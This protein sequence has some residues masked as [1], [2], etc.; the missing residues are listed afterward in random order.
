MSDKSYYLRYRGRV[1]GPYTLAQVKTVQQWGKL[2]PVHEIS[3]DKSTWKPA[4][5][6]AELFGPAP[7]AKPAEDKA[8]SPVIPRETP[9][10]AVADQASQQATHLIEFDCPN[11]S[12]VIKVPAQYGGRLGKCKACGAKVRI[13]EREKE[14]ATKKCPACGETIKAEAQKCRFCG[15]YLE[16]EAVK[17]G[18]FAELGVDELALATAAPTPPTVGQIKPK[19]ESRFDQSLLERIFAG[20]IPGLERIAS[21]LDMPVAVLASTL[22]TLT[23]VVIGAAYTFASGIP[24]ATPT[25][26][27]EADTMRLAGVIFYAI[28]VLSAIGVLRRS[29]FARVFLIILAV[30]AILGGVF[31]ILLPLSGASSLKDMGFDKVGAPYYLAQAAGLLWG[32][33]VFQ[34]LNTRHIKEWF[35]QGSASPHSGMRVCQGCGTVTPPGVVICTKC[36]LDLRTGRHVSATGSLGGAGSSDETLG[37]L[38]AALPALSTVLMWL[39]IPELSLLE[40][41][42]NKLLLI[43]VGTILLTSLLVLIDAQ[44]IGWGSLKGESSPFLLFLGCLLLWIVVYPLYLYKRQAHGMKNLCAVGLITALL[45]T[46]TWL[47]WGSV[48]E[49]HRADVQRQLEELEH[50]FRP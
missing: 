20:T 25:A 11:C 4:R 5:E 22:L 6:F 15:E 39:W 26:G 13:P 19:K 1:G 8:V 7:F 24:K 14:D 36:G 27:I 44:K 31:T 10:S 46:G 42:A 28:V 33:L 9:E 43:G 12:I 23:Y 29:N 18:L 2:S 17:D 41:V 48:I 47:Y 21:F 49:K 3:T 45:M 34:L 50:L 35:K 40:G 37:Y 32:M 30:L 16:L 38:A